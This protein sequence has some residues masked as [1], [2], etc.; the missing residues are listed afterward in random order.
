[1]LNERNKANKAEKNK[2]MKKAGMKRKNAG[3]KIEIDGD[4][5]HGT[6]GEERGKRRTARRVG[7]IVMKGK[8]GTT[9]TDGT[10]L[11]TRDGQRRKH[12]DEFLKNHS[13]GPQGKLPDHTVYQDMGYLMAES[14]GLISEIRSDAD[15][16]RAS[17][18]GSKVG[19][20]PPKSAGPPE[21]PT[22]YQKKL[23][24]QVAQQTPAER[25]ADVD[26]FYN[27][28]GQKK[29]AGT[30]EIKYVVSAAKEPTT[31]VKVSKAKGT[32]PM[33]GMR[34]RRKPK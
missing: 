2:A 5:P 8:T 25:Q 18:V 17:G 1:M 3:R 31:K 22:Q 21:E 10:R 24:R 12:A 13:A 9:A 4:H 30:N 34:R 14:L 7:P 6:Y 19:P 20:Q 28:Q 15:R 27:R 33:A 32:S 23:A 26:D 11:V 16:A 29:R